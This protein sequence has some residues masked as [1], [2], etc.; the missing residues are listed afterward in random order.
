MLLIDASSGSGYLDLKSRN[1]N[2]LIQPLKSFG[3]IAEATGKAEK[4]STRTAA[5]FKIKYSKS[6]VSICILETSSETLCNNVYALNWLGK[7]VVFISLKLP[8]GFFL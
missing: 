7:L 6:F 3:R 5:W 8:F 1:L 4:L 2:K